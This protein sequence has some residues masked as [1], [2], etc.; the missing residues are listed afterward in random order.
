MHR[1]SVRYSIALLSLVWQQLRQSS[2]GAHLHDYRS[3][4]GDIRMATSNDMEKFGEQFP[5]ND[6]PIRT[7]DCTRVAF[8]S[9]GVTT[10][11]WCTY[12]PYQFLKQY[13]SMVEAQEESGREDKLKAM[14]CELYQSGMCRRGTKCR[15][16]HLRP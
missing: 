7:Q 12:D 13:K 9:V 5:P 6:I 11:D 3:D 1:L 8:T 15:M 14:V 16:F 10:A 2:R 4:T